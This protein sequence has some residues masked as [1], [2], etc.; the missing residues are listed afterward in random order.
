[1]GSSG[2]T[3]SVAI[4]AQIE[5]VFGVLSHGLRMKTE[6]VGTKRQAGDFEAVADFGCKSRRLGSELQRTKSFE[7][8][9]Q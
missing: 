9:I 7:Q 4:S 3:E 1:M 8:T 2:G 6:I 5:L